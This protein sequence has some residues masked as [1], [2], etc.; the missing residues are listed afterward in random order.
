MT[1][2]RKS[3]SGNATPTTLAGAITNSSTTIPVSAIVGFPDT[4]V[5]PFVI[6]VDRGTSSEEKILIESYSGTN[7]IVETRGY[8]GTTAQA[9]GIGATVVHTID[10]NTIDQANDIVNAVGSVV[11]TS[12]AI[13]DTATEGTSA[14]PAAADH[15]HGRESFGSGGTTTS[16]VGDAPSDG[17]ATTVARADHK[18]GRESFG[19][20]A[21]VSALGDA[22]S[23]GTAISPSRSDHKHGRES[24]VGST[25]TP[26]P[27]TQAGG[28]GSA[29]VPS[30]GD[31]AHPFGQ[32]PEIIGVGGLLFGGSTALSG[33]LVQF[34]AVNGTPDVN[35][36]LTVNYPTAFPSA[37]CVVLLTNV[38]NNGAANQTLSIY[39]GNPPTT[40][41][42]TILNVV[43]GA[44]LTTSCEFQWFAIGQ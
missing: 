17:S 21:S 31:H 35:G 16:A 36:H 1:G 14:V 18:H 44:P 40:T 25:A 38:G 42:F 22:Q 26:Q 2:I 41:G 11:P 9:H 30:K 33:K 8:D 12:S 4:T 37:T 43:N 7:M 6:V 23:P 39:S 10:A 34:G 29:T 5:G 19:T 28:A 27:P 3:Y 32:T 13:G 24:F 20:S 15:K